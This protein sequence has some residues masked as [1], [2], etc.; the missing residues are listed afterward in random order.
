MDFVSAEE[1]HSKDHTVVDKDTDFVC[2]TDLSVLRMNKR[3][4][5]RAEE[6]RVVTDVY[7]ITPRED[8]DLKD[9]ENYFA[10]MVKPIGCE[11]GYF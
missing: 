9:F 8:S 5:H 11:N 10:G 4:A 6:E 3:V 1:I 7:F 2:D